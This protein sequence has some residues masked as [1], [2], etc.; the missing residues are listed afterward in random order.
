ME[1][2]WV[3]CMCSLFTQTGCLGCGHLAFGLARLLLVARLYLDHRIAL[4]VCTIETDLQLKM[5]I[6]VVVV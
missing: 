5:L 4:G 2:D 3:G 1:M 6:F